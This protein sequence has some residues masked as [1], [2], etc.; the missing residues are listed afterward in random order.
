VTSLPELFPVVEAPWHDGSPLWPWPIAEQKPFSHI[1]LTEDM[2]ELMIGSVIAQL[3]SYNQFEVGATA[4]GLLN[5]T[6]SAES[7]S[8]KGGIQASDGEREINPSCCCGLQEWR[9]WLACLASGES[10][11]MGHDP[12]PRIEWDG[13]TVR[14]WS[15]SAAPDAYAI[16]F[17]R[18][19]L[20]AELGKV[21]QRL[22]ALLPQVWKW[23]TAIGFTDPHALCRRFDECFGITG[24]VV[25]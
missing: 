8:L 21:E 17:K 2:S 18:D 12:T 7:L 13:D 10:P 20:I 22:R 1:R 6:V 16:E 19:R 23:A 14:V 3:V 24:P 15:D 5:T 25:C 4:S 9:A 11:W